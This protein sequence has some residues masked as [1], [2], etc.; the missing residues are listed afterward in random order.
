MAAYT[1]ALK[2]RTREREPLGMMRSSGKDWSSPRSRNR[3]YSPTT[4]TRMIDLDRSVQPALDPSLCT[5]EGPSSCVV[6]LK[7]LSL[8]VRDSCLTTCTTGFS[9][10][11][12]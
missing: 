6:H 4:R 11:F 12:T 10:S 1:E 7:S 3:C 8:G 5:G 2:E 9:A